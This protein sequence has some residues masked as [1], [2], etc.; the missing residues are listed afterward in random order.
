[1]LGLRCLLATKEKSPFGLDRSD[2]R[3]GLNWIYG[4]GVSIGVRK[5]WV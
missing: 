4:I 3:N 1:M 5:G 2:L